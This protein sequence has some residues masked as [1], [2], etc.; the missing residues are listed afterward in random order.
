MIAFASLNLVSVLGLAEDEPEGDGKGK[1]GKTEEVGPQPI[2]E[3]REA[4]NE[5]VAAEH[6]WR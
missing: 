3:K 4:L 1:E 2:W 6:R 5:Q